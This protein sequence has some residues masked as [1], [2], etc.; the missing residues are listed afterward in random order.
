MVSEQDVNLT[1]ICKSPD[2]FRSDLYEK[3][4]SKPRLLIVQAFHI[5]KTTGVGLTKILLRHCTQSLLLCLLAP[6]L[7]LRPTCN[8]FA[9]PA[10]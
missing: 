10:L 7:S 8:Y 3:H 2:F 1:Q 4:D 5:L 6:S 9:R